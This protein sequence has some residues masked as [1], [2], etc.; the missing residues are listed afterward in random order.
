MIHTNQYVLDTSR[1]S[2]IAYLLEQIDHGFVSRRI[3]L[4][5]QQVSLRP[6]VILLREKSEGAA[7]QRLARLGVDLESQGAIIDR[8]RKPVCITTQR[9][10]GIE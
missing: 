7:V 8:L 6:V 4:R 5:A 9:R 1:L 10:G 3:L 2:T